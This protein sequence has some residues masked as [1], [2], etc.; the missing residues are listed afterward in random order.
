M[1]LQMSRFT[2]P[3]IGI[4]HAKGSAGFWFEIWDNKNG[5]MPP[6]PENEFINQMRKWMEIK[7]YT[8]TILW[9]FLQQWEKSMH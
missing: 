7:Q 6:D 2:K 8:R 9:V 3:L 5:Y 4:S 1:N